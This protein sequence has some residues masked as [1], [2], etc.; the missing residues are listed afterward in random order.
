MQ[1]KDEEGA[2]AVYLRRQL[3][4]LHIRVN[5]VSPHKIKLWGC[6][7]YHH[8]H[9]HPH[10]QAHVTEDAPWGRRA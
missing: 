7:E 5:K 1:L 6:S 2:V 3:C 4:V 9:P 8:H 10:H